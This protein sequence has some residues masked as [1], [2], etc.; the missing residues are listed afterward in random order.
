MDSMSCIL[1]SDALS[2]SWFFFPFALC[3]TRENYR[4]WQWCYFQVPASLPG[5]RG[6]SIWRRAS[7]LCLC[8]CSGSQ[9]LKNIQFVQ[10]YQCEKKKKRHIV[11]WYNSDLVWTQ[12]VIVTLRL[13]IAGNYHKDIDRENS[14]IQYINPNR[15][16]SCIRFSQHSN[17]LEVTWHEGFWEVKKKSH[18]LK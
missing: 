9:G 15:C 16:F 6:K 10:K 18:Y 5:G 2:V 1:F 4:G 12:W 17:R 7:Y 3:L 8:W 11:D 14:I 13:K